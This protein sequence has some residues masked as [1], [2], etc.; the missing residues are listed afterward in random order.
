MRFKIGEKA[1][2]AKVEGVVKRYPYLHDEQAKNICNFEIWHGTRRV[3]E[4]TISDKEL[5]KIKGE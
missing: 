1:K 3:G 2:Y 5:T 4:I